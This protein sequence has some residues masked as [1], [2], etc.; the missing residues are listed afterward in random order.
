MKRIGRVK[1]SVLRLMNTF[2]IGTDES[3]FIKREKLKSNNKLNLT[4]HSSS[5]LK[6]KEMSHVFEI[7]LILIRGDGTGTQ[8]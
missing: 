6:I 8:L 4:C 3:L 5:L 2:L 7:Y 1:C